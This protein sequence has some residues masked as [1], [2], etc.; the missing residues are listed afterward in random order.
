MPVKV[1]WPQAVVADDLHLP[2]QLGADRGPEPAAG[3]PQPGEKREN[4]GK[5]P[6]LVK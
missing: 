6:L 3:P 4:A 2:L 5:S 1:R